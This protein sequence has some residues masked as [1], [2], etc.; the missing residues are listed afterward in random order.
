MLGGTES[1]TVPAE[2][3]CRSPVKDRTGCA[4]GFL[5]ALEMTTGEEGAW[6]G[7]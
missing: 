1:G 7:E 2:G 5:A 4:G 3:S 6:S